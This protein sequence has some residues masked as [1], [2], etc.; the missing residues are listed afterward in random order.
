[1]P[2]D[3]HAR[4]RQQAGWTAA[5][6]DYLIPKLNLPPQARVLEVGCGTGALLQ[7]MRSRLGG[8]VHGLDR[9][10]A[11]LRQAAHHA[12][13]NRLV[14]G[15]AHRLPYADRSFHLVYSHFFLLWAAN[16]LQ[17]LR[18]MKRVLQPGGHVL[19]LAEPD[20][21]ARIDYPDA[22]RALGA[23][24]RDALRRKGAEPDIGRRLPELFVQAGLDLQ[25]S[26]LLGA[27]WQQPP[28]RQAWQLEW[29]LLEA[30][31]AARMSSA[32]LQDLRQQDWE[33]R[34]AGR[35]VLFVPVFYAWGKRNDIII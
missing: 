35:R 13:G 4:F 21:A 33:D 5:L 9:A 10:A 29:A 26:G 1:M 31:L 17:A 22:Y 2:L 15:E 16:P 8:P 6:R 19:A 32:A 27:Q 24:Q 11:R 28:D 3:W 34:Q 14:Q 30:D 25:E 7:D 20:Y 12:P 23:A 18:E